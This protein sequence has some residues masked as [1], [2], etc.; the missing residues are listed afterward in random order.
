[1]QAETASAYASLGSHAQR[2]QE[3]HEGLYYDTELPSVDDLEIAAAAA[4]AA[5]DQS[6]S[7]S[8]STSDS[9]CETSEESHSD[10]AS[11]EATR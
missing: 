11:V 10:A 8:S 3:E 9:S 6:R 7:D 2:Y 1:M 4:Q 5:L